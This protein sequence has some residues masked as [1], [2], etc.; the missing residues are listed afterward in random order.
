MIC[1]VATIVQIKRRMLGDMMGE[2]KW[3]DLKDILK[4]KFVRIYWCLLRFWLELS[5]T[6]CF[7]LLTGSTEEKESR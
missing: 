4:V 1:E 5:G 2:Y 6:W 3:I 7:Y